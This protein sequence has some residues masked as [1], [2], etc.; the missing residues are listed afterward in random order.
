MATKLVS[1]YYR[2]DKQSQSIDLVI[3]VYPRQVK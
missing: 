1:A 2:T 3:T